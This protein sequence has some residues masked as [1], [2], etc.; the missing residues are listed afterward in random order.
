MAKDLQ[1]FFTVTVP[2]GSN[3]EVV[4][5]SLDGVTTDPQS[6]QYFLNLILTSGHNARIIFQMN[7]VYD[8]IRPYNLQPFPGLGSIAVFDAQ[9][10]FNHFN[11]LCWDRDT[12][13][14]VEIW[15]YI[16]SERA[17][18]RWGLDRLDLPPE[19]AQQAK[20]VHWEWVTEYSLSGPRRGPDFSLPHRRRR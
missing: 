10:M 17:E 20:E 4:I 7:Q 18:M 3:I 1:E 19:H 13:R 6:F 2:P 16:E 14:L 11:R 8:E 5:R 9:T 15:E 12:A